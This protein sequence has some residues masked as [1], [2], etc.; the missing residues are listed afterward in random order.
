VTLLA[1][2]SATDTV[3]VGLIRH[4]G[5]SAERVHLGGRAHAELLAPAIE[6]VC[7]V[8]GTEVADIER[9]AVDV[10][11]GLFTGLRVGVAT[12][13][14]LA[15]SLSVP[16]LGVSSLDILAAAAAASETVPGPAG[17]VAAV[18]DARRGEVFA[19]A[20]RFDRPAARPGEPDRGGHPIDPGD[21]RLDRPGAISPEALAAW[22]SDLAAE[23]GRVQVVGDGAVRYLGLLSGHDGLDLDLAGRL[24]APPPLALA[25]L[26]LARLSGGPPP[27]APADL[28]PDYRRQ[29]DARINWEQRLPRLPGPHEPQGGGNRQGAS[30]T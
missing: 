9:I 6:E 28:V 23:A 15:W 24:A 18:V 22:L 29:A 30:R 14:A 16:L 10:G 2:E 7:A 8:S 12:A 25:R 17:A 26:A 21:V 3:G 1:I 13:K 11:P 19:A 27:T 20:Y 4:D 5:G